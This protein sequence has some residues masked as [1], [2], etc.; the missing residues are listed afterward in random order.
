LVLLSLSF[1][2]FSVFFTLQMFRSM[3]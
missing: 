3:L 2:V 1:R